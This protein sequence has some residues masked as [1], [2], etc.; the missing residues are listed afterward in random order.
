MK[1][2]IG[3]Y[4]YQQFIEEISSRGRVALVGTNL[5]FTVPDENRARDLA[6]ELIDL[7]YAINLHSRAFFVAVKGPNDEQRIS[8][9]VAKDD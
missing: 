9:R 4:P 5:E 6:F 7:G 8:C 1:G 3:W 2:G